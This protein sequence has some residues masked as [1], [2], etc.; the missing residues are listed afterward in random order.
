MV[1]VT[2]NGDQVLFWLEFILVLYPGT[3]FRI[4]KPI[5]VIN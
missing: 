1:I 3:G 2:Q 5:N 4:E